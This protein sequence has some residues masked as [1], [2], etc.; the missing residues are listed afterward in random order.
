MI[1][2][3]VESPNVMKHEPKTQIMAKIRRRITPSILSGEKE[4]TPEDAFMVLNESSTGT[5]M[6]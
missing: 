6:W 3:V 4:K 5:W 1:T 2:G